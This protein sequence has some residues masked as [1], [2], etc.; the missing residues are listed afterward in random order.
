MTMIKVN[1]GV[2]RKIVRF[3]YNVTKKYPNTYSLEDAHKDAIKT[4]KDFNFIH[5]SYTKEEWTNN[6]YKVV[7]NKSGWYFAYYLKDGG[8][9]IMDVDNFRNMKECSTL[10]ISQ[11]P[12]LEYTITDYNCHGY[13]LVKSNKGLMNFVDKNDNLITNHW[14]T[15]YKTLK[16]PYGT[17]KVFVY[18]NVNGNCYALGLDKQ[19][20]FMGKKWTDLYTESRYG[21]T[22][23]YESQINNIIRE[24]LYKYIY[25]NRA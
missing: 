25:E 3:Y 2:K 20:H 12:K 18:I 6:N 11:K 5:T 14:F 22:F 21:K 13:R 7:R 4:S 24:T 19:I 9:Y 23:L 17:K 8:M 15:Q 1:K 16:K 10:N